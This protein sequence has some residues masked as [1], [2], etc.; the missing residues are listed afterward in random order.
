MSDAEKEK[1]VISDH[2]DSASVHIAVSNEI[3][4]TFDDTLLKNESLE[5]N[6]L[7]PYRI[8]GICFNTYILV[9]QGD[10]LLL[11]DKHAAHERIIFEKL[12][13]NLKKLTYASQMLMIPVNVKLSGD[14][15]SAA[16]EYSKEISDTGFCFSVNESKSTAS[17]DAIPDM[18]EL[19]CAEDVFLSM[20]DN[21]SKQNSYARMTRDAYYERALY[22]SSCKAAV[23]GGRMDSDENVRWIC[24]TLLSMPDIKVCPHGRPVITELEKRYIDR[25]FDRIK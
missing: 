14:E 21:L 3:K 17:I 24:D 8:I 9:E 19:S 4:N 20:L 22:Q 18:I 6:K 2:T 12:K 1:N 7:E 5:E 13:S 16:I 25:Q 10:K 11:I 15:L 23:K